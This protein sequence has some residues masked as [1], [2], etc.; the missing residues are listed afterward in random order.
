MINMLSG[1][2]RAVFRFMGSFGICRYTTNKG[3]R[4]YMLHLRCPQ[5]GTSDDLISL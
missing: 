2:A 3:W 1:C 5:E 4:D